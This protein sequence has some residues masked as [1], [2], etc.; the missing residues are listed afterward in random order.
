MHSN[1]KNARYL[2]LNVSAFF[3]L[4]GFR[5]DFCDITVTSMRFLHAGQGN[6][7]VSFSVY[8]HIHVCNLYWKKECPRIA[9]RRLVAYLSRPMRIYL[10]LIG[11]AGLTCR[12]MNRRFDVQTTVFFMGIL[13]F[14]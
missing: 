11:S 4:S 8:F 9:C 14:R 5:H 1:E 10:G 6:L 3:S 12:N 13:V 7:T 2:M